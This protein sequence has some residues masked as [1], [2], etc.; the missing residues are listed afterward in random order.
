MYKKTGAVED[1]RVASAEPAHKSMDRRRRVDRKQEAHA[2]S[3][4]GDGP[5]MADQRRL[6]VLSGALHRLPHGG[7]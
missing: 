4:G 2:R 3:M 7:C 6:A 1:E 5:L